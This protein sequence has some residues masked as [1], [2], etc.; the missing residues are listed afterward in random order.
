MTTSNLSI[1]V[2]PNFIRPQVETSETL[3][4]FEDSNIIFDVL[5]QVAPGILSEMD[6]G[7]NHNDFSDISALELKRLNA[8]V[9]AP[10]TLEEEKPRSEPRRLTLENLQNVGIDLEMTPAVHMGYLNKKTDARSSKL[11]WGHWNLRYFVLWRN[12]KFAYFENSQEYFNGKKPKLSRTY[13]IPVPDSQFQLTS[14][15]YHF[16][17]SATVCLSLFFVVVVQIIV[18][19]L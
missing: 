14:R 17:D 13:Y 16:G 7:V 11:K 1:V 8:F 3:M 18:I 4:R 10:S 5:I 15:S 9:Y 19:F 6:S 2:S 12:G